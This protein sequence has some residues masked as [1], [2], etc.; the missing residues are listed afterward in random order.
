MSSYIRQRMNLFKNRNFCWYFLSCIMT[1]FSGGLLYI[2]VT[3][4]VV[5]LEGS[6]LSVALVLFCFWLPMVVL[7]PIVGVLTDRYSR[8]TLL[9]WANAYRAL[10]LAFFL[11]LM[12]NFYS[13]YEFYL[14]MLFDG[15]ALSLIFPVVFSLIRDVV[16][17][18]QLMHAN[19]TI[20]MGYEFG[21]VLGMGLS[22]FVIYFMGS[23]WALILNVIFYALAALC[24]LM[25]K[26]EKKIQLGVK[27]IR[28][29]L[30]D[31]KEGWRYILKRKKLCM[32][33]AVQLFLMVQFM[34]MPVLLAPFATYILHATVKQFGWIEVC[35]SI[36]VIAGGFVLP[37]IA[38]YV[39]RPRVVIAALIW[40]MVSYVCFI[41]T[42]HV[43]WAMVLFFMMGIGY[44]A[45]PLVMTRSQELTEIR[46][47]GRVQST[48]TAFA[49]FSIL[50]VYWFVGLSGEYIAP[51]YLYVIQIAFC[52]IAFILVLIDLKVEHV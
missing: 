30:N 29:V 41:Q 16:P 44:G 35:L 9:G 8:K 1:T 11:I 10:S 27:N 49:S 23:H 20:D 19:A 14:L 40:I 43:S 46:F 21:N 5:H 7:S 31:Y 13:V 32:N 48:F 17:E 22:G 15:I 52:V 18:R 2:N 26:L 24:V 39:G 36:G 47:Q 3:W 34:T 42:T 50:F 38:H 37:W 12:L 51:N 33:Y 4:S 45:W 25:I 28:Q 6:V